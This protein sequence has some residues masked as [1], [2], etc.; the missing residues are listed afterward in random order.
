[1]KKLIRKIMKP[2]VITMNT[3]NDNF[4]LLYV[5]VSKYLKSR[6]TFKMTMM[7]MT[8]SPAYIIDNR[9]EAEM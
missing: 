7:K 9:I 6:F 3:P 4:N 2:I 5:S 1:M 8:T